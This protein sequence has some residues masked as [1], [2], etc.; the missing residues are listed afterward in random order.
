[1]HAGSHSSCGRCGCSTC[2]GTCVQY[3]CACVCVPLHWMNNF[4]GKLCTDCTLQLPRRVWSLCLCHTQ[5]VV[6]HSRAGRARLAAFLIDEAEVTLGDVIG[7]G[8]CGRV[9]RATWGV[10]TICVKVCALVL[11]LSRYHRRAAS[12]SP[13]PRPL[14]SSPVVHMCTSMKCHV[15][16]S[17]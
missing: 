10:Q 16:L 15:R 7:Q 2:Y 8:S 17:K 12:C 5:S 1:M 6:A 11:L 4:R 9:L 3:I 14:T 13:P